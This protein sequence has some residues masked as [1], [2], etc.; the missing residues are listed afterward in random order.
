LWKNKRA[1][2]AAKGLPMSFPI[3]PRAVDRLQRGKA[4]TRSMGKKLYRKYLDSP[5]WQEKRLQYKKDYCEICGSRFGLNLHHVSYKNLLVESEKD[6]VTLCRYCH[7]ACHI[8]VLGDHKLKNPSRA[9]YRIVNRM[10]N[11]LRLKR[12]ATAIFLRR[13]YSIQYGTKNLPDLDYFRSIFLHKIRNKLFPF[14]FAI[15]KM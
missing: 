3:R 2:K 11:G 15:A 1:L 6:F 4:L 5:E 14:C 13:R 9:T 8:S 12:D 7:E 10:R